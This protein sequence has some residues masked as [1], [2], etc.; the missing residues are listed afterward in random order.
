MHRSQVSRLDDIMDS[1][2]FKPFSVVL[3]H[4][5]LAFSLSMHDD[6]GKKMEKLL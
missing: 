4:H 3:Q 1:R 2:F 6:G 5:T